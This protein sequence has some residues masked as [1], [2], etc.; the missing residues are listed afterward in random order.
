M[1]TTETMSI[2]KALAELK[3]LDSRITNALNNGAFITTKKNNQEKVKGQ[4]V[5]DFVSA[6]ESS[7]DKVYDLIRRRNAIKN[8]VCVSNANT[9]VKIGGKDYTVTQAIEKKNHGLEYYKNLRNIL[10]RQFGMCKKE[11]ETYNASLQKKAE[12]FV[13][14]LMGNKDGKTNTEDYENVVNTYI[15]SNTM[16]LIDP[17]GLEK[18]IEELDDMINNFMP[19]VDAALSCSNALTN[20]TIVY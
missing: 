6:A 5:P 15:K 14:S 17:L 4:S 1:S 2:H 10:A 8:E 19:E 16:E 7:Y 20:I 18:K 9:W 11:V 12:E 13:T 3:V